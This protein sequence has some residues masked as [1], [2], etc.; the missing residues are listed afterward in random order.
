MSNET[1]DKLQ[2]RRLEVWDNVKAIADRAAEEN[3]ALTDT[4]EREYTTLDTEL[5]KLD[6]RIEDILKGEQRAK[7]AEDAV[8][9]L[10]GKSVE[11]AANGAPIALAKTMEQE[12]AELRA[13]L[14]G[15]TRTFELRMPNAIERRVAYTSGVP[16]PTGFSGQ[17]YQYLV[18]TSSIRQA[19]PRVYTTSSGENLV[20]PRSTAEGAALWTAE[21]AALTASDPTISSITLGAHKLG[22][23]LQVSSELV[24]DTGFDLVGF[25]AESCGRNIGVAA[26]TAYVLGTGTTQPTGF[27]SAA[28][29]GVTAASGT[30]FA[31][32][33]AAG[34][35]GD[36][37]I[38]LYYSVIPQYRGRASWVMN[39]ATVKGVRKVRDTSGQYLWQPSLQAGQPDTLLGRPVY[40]DPNM[41]TFGASKRIV[42]FGDFGSYAIRD[43]TPLR[44][45]RSDEYAFNVDLTSYRVLYR[46]D[47]AVLD[48]NGIKV[49][50]MNSS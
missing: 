39:D 27:L 3:R 8:A 21:G 28:S 30:G 19:N 25:I 32:G 24:S 1:V 37:L 23:I 44:F 26:D 50:A 20:I 14:R 18:D 17:L 33:V 49:L 11:R 9:R 45:D 4:E 31:T 12:D 2:K 41:D 5:D 13:F 10:A 34:N 38:D 46:T 40:A 35:G 48:A 43:V 47:G 42:A 29:V 7:D 22:K 15:E 36:L 6:K 16:M